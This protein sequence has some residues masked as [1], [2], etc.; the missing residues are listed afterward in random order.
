MNNS[1][2]SCSNT[3]AI[4]SENIGPITLIGLLT[5]ITIMLFTV[6]GNLLVIISVI[7]EKKLRQQIS[8]YLILSLAVTD[9]IVGVY[10]I[11]IR[12]YSSDH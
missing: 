1:N 11:P 6:C 12:I 10:V 3:V 8:N 9:L 5:A 2:T 4:I 7:R